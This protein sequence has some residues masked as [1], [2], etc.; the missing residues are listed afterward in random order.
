MEEEKPKTGKREN[1]GLMFSIIAIVLVLFMMFLIP[2]GPMKKYKATERELAHLEDELEVV[3]QAKQDEMARLQRQEEVMRRLEA[4]PANFDL[5]SF[6]NRVLTETGLKD[7]ANLENYRPRLIRSQ[8][9]EDVTL[10]RLRLNGIVLADLI[11]VLHAVYSSENLIVVHKVD[12]IRP[13]SSDQG[14]ECSLTLLSPKP[15][16]AA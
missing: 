2:T 8:E 16:K 13:A 9:P 4:R 10:V 11:D 7:H 5:W 1:T 3:R 6:M 12:Y 15:L 14:L